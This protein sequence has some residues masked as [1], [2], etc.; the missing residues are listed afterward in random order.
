MAPGNSPPIEADPL[1]HCRHR[2]VQQVPAKSTTADLGSWPSARPGPEP[3][4]S[5]TC[6]RGLRRTAFPT[7]RR[8]TNHLGRANIGGFA[9]FHG[10]WKARGGLR[11]N[12]KAGELSG[13]SDTRSTPENDISIPPHRFLACHQFWGQRYGLTADLWNSHVEQEAGPGCGRLLQLLRGPQ[14]HAQ[15]RKKGVSALRLFNNHTQ[16]WELKDGRGKI[17]FVAKSRNQCLGCEQQNL[18]I[19]CSNLGDETEQ[20]HLEALARLELNTSP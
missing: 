11:Y 14:D 1:H 4:R 15:A 19:E 16:Q 6:H 17:R 20:V 2:C 12:K 18:Q 9:G 8:K 7:A 5:Y 3:G 10:K 13:S